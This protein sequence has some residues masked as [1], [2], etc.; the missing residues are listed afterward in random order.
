MGNNIIATVNL[1]FCCRWAVLGE[2][3]GFREND[4]VSRNNHQLL[5]GSGKWRDQRGRKASRSSPA[6]TSQDSHTVVKMYL[7]LTPPK[8]TGRSGYSLAIT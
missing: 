3:G 4:E 7:V 2:R 1:Y 5:D 6:K 8:K